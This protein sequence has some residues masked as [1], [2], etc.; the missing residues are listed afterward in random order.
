MTFTLRAATLDD[1]ERVALLLTEYRPEPV[2]ADR[3]R[4]WHRNAPADRIVHMAMTT[5]GSG[6]A[7]T[8][9]DPSHPEGDFL[10]RVLVTAPAC[11]RGAGGALLADL[12]D[13]AR[14]HGGLRLCAGV[15]ESVTAGM[16][17]ATKHG[18]TAY[19][20]LFESRLDPR[21]VS[22][23]ELELQAPPGITVTDLAAWGDTEP[24]RRAIWQLHN[25]AGR[26]EPGNDDEATP[27][28]DYARQ[29]YDRESF[30]ARRHFV[31]LAGDRLVGF[32][33]LDYFAATESLYH[34]GMAVDR[35][36][37]GR[38]VASALKRATIAYGR[39]IGAAYLRTHNDS[40][41]A[42]MLAINRRYG[43]Q[44]RPG[45]VWVAKAL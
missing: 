22:K 27:F 9:R 43:Y 14:A 10:A 19:Q 25:D 11:G 16:A 42:P 30:D 6:Y 35:E 21:T 15:D 1:V 13:F 39:Q 18:Y 2:T 34:Q 24:H 28:E 32:A 4:E 17:F 8:F 12:E 29:A 7:D 5:D 37:R 40:R 33:L 3:L 26:D 38:G 23:A 44:P 41:N 20:H 36:V 45:Q 31:A